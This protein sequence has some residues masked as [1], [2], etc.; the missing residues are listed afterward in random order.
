MLKYHLNYFELFN[1]QSKTGYDTLVQNV[2]L[3]KIIYLMSTIIV[4]VDIELKT[5]FNRKKCLESKLL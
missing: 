3:K 4:D 1:F 2:V 5:K